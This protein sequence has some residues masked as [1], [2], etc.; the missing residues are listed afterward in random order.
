MTIGIYCIE[1][2]DS[3]KKYIGKSKVIEQRF[4]THRSELKREIRK[5]DTNRKLY[6]AVRK[7]G[8]DRFKFY[9]LESFDHLD[10]DVLT[11]SELKWMDYYESCTKK[12]YNLR[13]DSRTKCTVHE[14]T[15]QL[16]KDRHA[17]GKYY[18]EEWRIKIGVNS[19]E[20]WK[21]KNKL[22]KM[23]ENVSKAKRKYN[24]LQYTRDGQFIKK[25]DSIKEI[26]E[27]NPSYKWQNVY[28][29]C[30]GYKKTYMNYI[31]KK[32]LKI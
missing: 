26:V 1:H 9:I 28:S 2:I 6:N 13:R 17:S 19:K 15:I 16:I 30:N 18:T 32:E 8:L 5:K 11:D 14:S 24:F 23:A 12:G 27:S 31:W 20:M 22:R 21:D 4:I 29:V 25:W 10:D 3:G 7:Y